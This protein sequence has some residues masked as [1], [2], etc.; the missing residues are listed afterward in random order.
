MR[1]PSNSEDEAAGSVTL[2]ASVLDA[3]VPVRA[4]LVADNEEVYLKS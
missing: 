4:L 3:S 2:A 1:A